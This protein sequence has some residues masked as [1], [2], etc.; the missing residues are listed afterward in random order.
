M[1][2]EMKRTRTNKIT[3]EKYILTNDPSMTAW[4][5]AVVD[6]VGYTVIDCGTIKTEPGGKKLRIR[7]G[8]DRMRRVSE[9]NAVLLK[10]IKQY[11]IGFIFSELPHG[12]Q[13][14]SAAVMIGIVAGIIQTISDCLGIGVEWYSEGDAKRC[15]SGKRSV[16]KDEMVQIISKLYDVPWRG[17]KWHDQGVAD[18][19]AVFHVARQQSNV[20]KLWR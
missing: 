9:I 13:S 2:E 7:K 12:S 19:L 10:V 4:G 20:L 16:A 5:W 17:V 3:K 6:P 14:A 15:V 18:A 11:N 8:D 1:M